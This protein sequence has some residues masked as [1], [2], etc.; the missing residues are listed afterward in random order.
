MGR[1][2]L[3]VR[4]H[5]VEGRAFVK[6]AARHDRADLS[7]IRDVHE[8]VGIQ[9]DE[10][11]ES[12][13]GHGSHRGFPPEKAGRARRRGAERLGRRQS[14]FDEPPQFVV[15]AEAREAV[16]VHLVGSGEKGNA[17]LVQFTDESQVVALVADVLSEFG[18]R[19]G[20]GSPTDEELTRLPGSYAA[21]GGAFWVARGDGG[22]LLGT[23]GVFPVG[24]GA[25]EL[26]K[27]YLRPAARGRGVGSR[28]LAEA[29]AFAREQ[30][31]ERLVLDT[32]EPMKAAI[33]FYEANGFVRDDAQ[34]R[35]ARCSRGY[36]RVL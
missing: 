2:V 33:A 25:F 15:E 28:L 24:D 3:H 7:G 17:R 5:P 9:H 1:Y 35:A 31:A 14:R 18:L 26:R 22:A 30:A 36:V 10:V 34:M 11:G 23:C 4:E 19:F 32:A 16:R 12:S 27:M 6:H 13:F 8:R 29:I 21:R 20:D